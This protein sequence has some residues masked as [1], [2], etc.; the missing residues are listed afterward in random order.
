MG[1]LLAAV[2]SGYRNVA[3]LD[4]KEIMESAQLSE[5]L[6]RLGVLAA[7]GPAAGQLKEGLDA[8]LIAQ[9]GQGILGV[10]RGDVDPGELVESIKT[11]ASQ[12]ES[13]DHG[14]FEVLTV[15]VELPFFSLVLAVA[16]LDDT[17][18][19]FGVGSSVEGSSGLVKSALD[20]ATGAAAGLASDPSVR[21]L[22]DGLPQGFA[23]TLDPGCS[24]LRD[25]EACTGSVVSAKADGE[26]GAVHG[27]FLFADAEAASAGLPAIEETASQIG[28]PSSPLSAIEATVDGSSVRIEGTVELEAALAWAMGQVGT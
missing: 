21:A 18:V 17:T 2:P 6:D 11:P 8:I 4:L 25:I 28:G 1:E 10:L 22:L 12:V 15:G 3:F 14:E 23:V 19:L 16:R 5:S 24:L 9:G 20:A 7:L 26:Q 27:V 13:E